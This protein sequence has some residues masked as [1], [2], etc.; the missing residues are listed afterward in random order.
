[1][2]LFFVR[3]FSKLNTTLYTLLEFFIGYGET[4]F[5][6]IN[7]DILLLRCVYST[8][9]TRCMGCILIQFVCLAIL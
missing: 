1:M 3:D 2:A 4:G 6:P 9:H 5:K 7:I 8:P